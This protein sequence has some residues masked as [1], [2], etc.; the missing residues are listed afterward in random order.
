MSDKE[1]TEQIRSNTAAWKR[2]ILRDHVAQVELWADV[3]LGKV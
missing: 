3:L 1:I 2:T